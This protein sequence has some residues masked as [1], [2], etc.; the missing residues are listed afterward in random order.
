MG[1]SPKKKKILRTR[2]SFTIARHGRL[3][4]SSVRDIY[5]NY[6]ET[7][8]QSNAHDITLI[9][10]GRRKKVFECLSDHFVQYC[11]FID[12]DIL[13]AKKQKPVVFFYTIAYRAV[14]SGVQRSSEAHSDSHRYDTTLHDGILSTWFVL[15][16]PCPQSVSVRADVRIIPLQ[17]DYIPVLFTST[18]YFRDVSWRFVWYHRVWIGL[19]ECPPRSCV[20]LAPPF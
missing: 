1:I 18:V 3:W 16:D 20:S 9:S 5:S 13:R 14:Q 4:R 8:A 19:N 10:H 2:F 11:I 15:Y 17:N 7:N 12:W 6:L